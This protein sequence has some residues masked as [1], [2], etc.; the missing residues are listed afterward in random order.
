M[1]QQQ[2]ITSSKSFTLTEECDKFISNLL[3]EQ[4]EVIEIVDDSPTHSTPSSHLWLK[5]GSVHLYQTERRNLLN[6]KWLSSLHMNAAQILLKSQ[7]SHL[8]GLQ[9][10][11]SQF[12]P[13]ENL[14]NAIQILHIARNHW[15]VLTT[16]DCGPRC[17]ARYYDSLY[18]HKTCTLDMQLII[19]KRLLTDS[20]KLDIE[21]MKISQQS[22]NADCGLFAIAIAT[23]LAAGSDPTQLVFHQSEMREHLAEC[24]EKKVMKEFPVKRKKRVEEKILKIL[25]ICLCPICRGPDDGSEMIACDTC[26]K[27]YHKRCVPEYDQTVQTWKCPVC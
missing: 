17:Q 27:W 11:L 9:T 19:S 18:T 16:I 15:S 13:M 25:T 5:F 24:L 12:K 7:F 10:T 23:A 2:I 14:A 8:G 3:H 26:D 1:F 21:I 6:G 4:I 22:G 20:H